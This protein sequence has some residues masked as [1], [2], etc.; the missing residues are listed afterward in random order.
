MDSN[1]IFYINVL[2]LN[3]DDVVAAKVEEKSGG[4]LLTTISIMRL[5][6]TNY[7]SRNG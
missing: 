2:L 3:K 7:T 5:L 4:I 1:K 6:C